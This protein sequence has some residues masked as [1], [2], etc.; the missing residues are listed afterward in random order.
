MTTLLLNLLLNII[1]LICLFVNSFSKNS[2]K[3]HKKCPSA[4]VGDGLLN[5]AHRTCAQW[6]LFNKPEQRYDQRLRL[7]TL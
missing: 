7:N 2:C 4:K 3:M 1:R 6:A 5:N